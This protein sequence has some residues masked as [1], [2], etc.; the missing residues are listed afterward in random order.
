M[1][2]NVFDTSSVVCDSSLMPI[3]VL[4][5]LKE[6]IGR[7]VT[8]YSGNWWTKT[9]QNENKIKWNN[10]SKYC[11]F[12][13]WFQFNAYMSL[14]REMISRVETEHRGKLEQLDQMKQEQNKL[15][16]TK[17]T[18]N[19]DKTLISGVTDDQPQ[20]MVNCFVLWIC[21]NGEILKGFKTWLKIRALEHAFVR[22]IKL[23]R[24]HYWLCS[25]QVPRLLIN[26]WFMYLKQIF[27]KTAWNS[28][29]PVF[30]TAF[31]K[32]FCLEL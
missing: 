16:I 32:D 9:R 26:L 11:A 13:L 3:W 28:N 15:E 30:R 5:L 25:Q 2:G 18:E 22:S 4:W 8:E 12:N 29:K 23:A 17:I 1:S 21:L 7:I 27:G 14:I 31:Q 10:H 19:D 20:T 6:V 24:D